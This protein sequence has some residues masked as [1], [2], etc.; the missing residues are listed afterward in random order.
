MLFFI[1]ITDTFGGEA[2]YSWVT[3]HIFQGNTARGVINRLS[4]LSGIHWHC[5]GDYGE[6]KRYDSA[7][8]AT[9]FFIAPYDADSHA[10]F[11]GLETDE[12]KM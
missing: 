6:S 12:R 2:N 4:R 8:G 3:R 11:C 1:E 10:M 7:T 5:T 9:C